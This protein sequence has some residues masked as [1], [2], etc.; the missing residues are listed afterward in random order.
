MQN[1]AIVKR[2]RTIVTLKNN[3]NVSDN[4][5]LRSHYRQSQSYPESPIH[6]LSYGHDY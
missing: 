5:N 4:L 6:L 1:M 3:S 2:A